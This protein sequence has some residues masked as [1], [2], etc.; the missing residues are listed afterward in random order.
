MMLPATGLIAQA[1]ARATPA[2]LTLPTTSLLA[3][4][5]ARVGVTNVSGACSAWADQSG[6]GWHASQSTAGKR[7]VVSSTAGFPSLL[8]SNAGATA[9]NVPSIS[10]SAGIKTVYCVK[11]ATAA[12]GYASL[13]D[14]Q[15]GRMMFGHMA[16]TQYG[17]HDGTDRDSGIVATTGLA[18]LAFECT[19]GSARVWVN[20]TVGST[21]GF[22]V[23]RAVGG[24]VV[25]G[26]NN[27]GTGLHFNGH[28][29]FLAIYN[30]ARNTAVEDYITQEWGV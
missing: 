6:N 11:N 4:W 27:A 1:G 8:F 17:V 12:A 2:P 18:R 24:G 21:A 16:G 28:I 23:N 5:D 26:A 22:T 7:P 13:F 9:L 15:T 10:A 30:A 19:T 14:V 20:G 25:I 29:L 3:A